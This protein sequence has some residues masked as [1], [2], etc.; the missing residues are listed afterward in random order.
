MAD[1][2]IAGLAALTLVA[3]LI[4]A[5]TGTRSLE[6]TDRQRNDEDRGYRGR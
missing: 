1:T 2:F 5:L 4:V 6:K 3:A